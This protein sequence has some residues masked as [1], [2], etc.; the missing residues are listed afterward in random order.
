MVYPSSVWD[1]DVRYE[2][3]Q[4]D[5]EMRQLVHDS[6][7]RFVGS[8]TIV[9]KLHTSFNYMNIPLRYLGFSQTVLVN[10]CDRC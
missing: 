6:K 9:T 5:P 1:S 4:S 8:F 10:G 2:M 7:R 3:A